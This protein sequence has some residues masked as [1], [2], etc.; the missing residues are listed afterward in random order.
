[1]RKLE[2]AVLPVKLVLPFKHTGTTGGSNLAQEILQGG[3]HVANLNHLKHV[4]IS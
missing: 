2:L 4:Q 3:E 1:V